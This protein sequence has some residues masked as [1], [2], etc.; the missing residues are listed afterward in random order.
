MPESPEL[1]TKINE[2]LSYVRLMP[3]L[4]RANAKEL[5]NLYMRFFK[6]KKRA[7]RVFRATDGERKS[8]KIAEDLNLHVQAISNEYTELED[9]GLVTQ[10]D[11]GL[12]KKTPIDSILGLT[13]KLEKIL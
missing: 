7:A 8:G 5:T 11:W 12:Y 3:Y 4:V 2:I 10:I 1:H 9:L 13:R 6:R